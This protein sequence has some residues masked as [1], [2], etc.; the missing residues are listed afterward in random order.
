MLKLVGIEASPNCSCNARANF[1]NVQG[2]DWCEQN[3]D[4]IVTWLRE[5][6]NARGLPFFQ[7]GAT[8]IVKRAIKLARKKESKRAAGS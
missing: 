6:A 3:L 7:Y 8:L 4:E 2:C 1:M 5:E